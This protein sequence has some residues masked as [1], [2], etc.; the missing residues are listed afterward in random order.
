MRKNKTL[1]KL[2]Y[3]T[4]LIALLLRVPAISASGQ[5]PIN[6]AQADVTLPEVK[7]EDTAVT[8]SEMTE[9]YVANGSRTATKTDT[10][11]LELPQAISVVTE[12]ELTDR[13]VQTLQE[14]M[15][16]VPGVTADSYGLD[17]RGDWLFIR[18]AEHTEYLDGLRVFSQGFNIPRPDPYTLEQIDV[19]RGP[20]SV[21][22]GSGTPGGLVNMRSKRPKQDA[23][24]E[25]ELQ[26][27][28]FDRKQARVDFT[29]PLTKQ[30]DWL[31]RFVGLVRDTDTQV[32]FTSNNRWQLAPSITWKPDDK[33]QLT[34]LAD[35]R[36]DRTH[37]ATSAFPPHSGTI[38][39]NPNGFIPD[40]RF[41]GEPGFDHYFIRQKSIG[42]EFAHQFDDHWAFRQNGRFAD[43]DLDYTSL[44]PDIFYGVGNNQFP[45]D[46]VGQRKVQR[47]GWVNQQSAENF[48]LDNQL[49]AKYDLGFSHHT[50]LAGVDYFHSFI[51]L[52]NGFSFSSTLFDLYNPVYGQV[53]ASE[54]P[55][56]SD[57]PDQTVD[58]IGVYAQDQ[59]KFG[60]HLT[61][62]GGLRHDW[63]DNHT[64]GGEAQR[65][66]ALTGRVGLVYLSDL[67]L[68][69]YVSYSQSFNPELGTTRL[70]D[71]FKPKRGEQYEVGLRY[72]PESS[73]SYLRLSAYDLT[74]TNRLT[75]DPVNPN[76]SV[77]KSS[78]HAWGIEFEGVANLTENIDLIAN[79]AY[80]DATTKDNITG[81]T[82]NIAEIH[83][84][85]GSLWSTYKFSLVGI[86]G[87]KVGGGV[88]YIG[89]NH[90][91]AGKLNVPAVTLFDAMLAYENKDWRVAFNANNLTDESYLSTC[92]SRGDCWYGSR[93]SF[94]GSLSYK[95]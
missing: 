93:G 63:L 3:S 41:T 29:G 89:A 23:E 1:N 85:T 54:L 28:N 82:R 11:L 88:R 39:N 73:N 50:L 90:D 65:D 42:W 94:V 38:S 30:G 56:A 91:E 71:N 15:R 21:L 2:P 35:F 44:Y 46:P 5:Q 17:N 67:G 83:P 62:T 57:L 70:D 79:Y 9:D 60:K 92:L 80:T 61:L 95:F 76:F 13:G 48:T 55:V 74:E 18:G 45:V 36:E 31:Y 16:Y 78:A 86:S 14:A 77:Q 69:P 72:Q 27:G 25:I 12:Q 68:A 10:P 40:N 43:M 26:Y 22:Y 75:S 49:E 20:A 7:V 53:P 24:R 8:P 33:T 6:Q 52:R 37:G 58:Q 81:E 59:I 32:D 66:T 51:D 64:E 47:F 34:L 84:H 19:V 87:F 4:F